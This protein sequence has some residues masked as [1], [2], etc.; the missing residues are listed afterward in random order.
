MS[1]EKHLLSER[2]IFEYG[3]SCREFAGLG[4]VRAWTLGVA[5]KAS[6]HVVAPR[7]SGFCKFESDTTITNYIV[8]T[9]WHVWSTSVVAWWAGGVVAGSECDVTGLLSRRSAA[10]YFCSSRG[11]CSDMLRETGQIFCHN[12]LR[13]V[14]EECTGVFHDFLDPAPILARILCYAMLRGFGN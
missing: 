8:L 4:L 6:C 2:I 1:G 10:L 5:C 12:T 9:F 11:A 13:E 3:S 7:K 14:K